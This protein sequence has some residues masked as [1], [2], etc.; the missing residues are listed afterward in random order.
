MYRSLV[1]GFYK[2]T[3]LALLENDINRKNTFER[4]GIRLQDKRKI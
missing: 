4:L 1:Q 3:S 2:N